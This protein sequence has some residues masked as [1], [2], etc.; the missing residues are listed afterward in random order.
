L[1]SHLTEEKVDDLTEK[2]QIARYKQAFEKANEAIRKQNESIRQL[3]DEVTRLKAQINASTSSVSNRPAGKSLAFTPDDSGNYPAPPFPVSALK[4]HQTGNVQVEIV[5]GTNG[6]PA[7]VSI[8]VSS[9]VPLLD[10]HTVDWVKSKWHGPEGAV[11]RY[12]W[13]CTYSVD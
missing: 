4:Q 8:G 2:E 5:V 6:L 10:K 3:N 9:G 11:R 13:N 12:H 1:P 7:D